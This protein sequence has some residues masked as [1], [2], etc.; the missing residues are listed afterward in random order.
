[1]DLEG[2][3]KDLSLYHRNKND[4]KILYINER[5]NKSLETYYKELSSSL[6]YLSNRNQ[7][8]LAKKVRNMKWKTLLMI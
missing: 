2:M 1:M 6:D 7:E 5:L 8:N 3:L 4:L